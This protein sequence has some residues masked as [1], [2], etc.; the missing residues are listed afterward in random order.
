MKWLLVLLSGYLC[1]AAGAGTIWIDTDPSI[2]LP[3][4]EVDDAYAL[5]LA[6]HS[7]E[8]QLAGIS[9]T[10]GNAS[11]D[12]TT[13]VAADLASRFGA[14]V[15]VVRGAAS[16]AN[17]G[18]ETSASA[19]LAVALR[20]DQLT[21]LALGPLTNLATF[22]QLHRELG[23]HIEQVIFVGGKSSGATLGF[24]PNDSFRIHDANVVKDPA[25]VRVVFESKLRILLAPI[26]TSSRLL[27]DA[28]SLHALRAGDSAGKYLAQNSDAWFWFW[29]HIARAKGAPI[30]D[31][32]A[33]LCAARPD[34]LQIE[35]RGATLKENS[36]NLVVTPLPS[37]GGRAVEFCISLKPMT[38]EVVMKRLRN[39]QSHASI[40]AK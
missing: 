18:R 31:A 12:G 5:L 27:L 34:L 4:R 13:R 17:L 8:L 26:E 3:L 40:R 35:N 6:F 37:D 1:G 20:E 28:E 30:F 11:V 29:T 15:A 33:V 7:P 38:M 21:Y 9:T 22:L 25:A 23:R 24:G 19:A 16:P 10:Y 2:G 39:E 14:H 36:G 32:L